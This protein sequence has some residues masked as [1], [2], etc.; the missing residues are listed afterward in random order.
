METD[1]LIIG[2]GLTGTVIASRIAEA[3]PNYE[4]TLVEAGTN[5]HS[6]PI[7]LAPAQAHALRESDHVWKDLST[8]QRHL[9]GRTISAITGKT[10][11]GSSAVNAGFWTR[12]SATDYDDWASKV[13]G[14]ERW[15]YESQLPYFKKSETWYDPQSNQDDHGFQGPVKVHSAKET[16][17]YPLREQVANAFL[18]AGIGLKLN[19]DAQAGDPIGISEWTENWHQGKSGVKVLTNAVAGKLLLDKGDSVDTHTAAKGVELVDGTIILARKEIVICCGAFRTPQLLMLSG[20]GPK[21]QLEAF[22]IPIILENEAVGQKLHD[23]I[24]LSMFYK[25]RNGSEKGWALGSPSFNKPEYAMGSPV[26]WLAI[27]SVNQENIKRGLALD[28]EREDHFLLVPGR[29]HTEMVIVYGPV[30]IGIPGLKPPL[31]GSIITTAVLNLLPTSRGSVTI[32]SSSATVSPNI[33][34]NYYAT[35]TDREILRAGIR[36]LLKVL[37]N[38]EDGVLDGE[39]VIEPWKSLTLDST[40]DDIDGRVKA[41][42]STWYHFGGSAAMGTVVDADLRVMGV[43]GLRIGDVSILPGPLGGHYQAAMYALAE[44]AADLII[45]GAK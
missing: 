26:D 7:I 3:L 27:S 36:N 4:V 24:S 43:R 14:G 32:T 1:Y 42:A 23:Q 31:D 11:S 6:N 22:N 12:C 8:P 35:H 39:L 29:P 45:E 37:N 15:R 41:T 33:D 19:K 2:G 21:A 40:D 20:I 44:Q 17:S 18:N 25:L 30:G 28:Q 16:R 34:P 13:P 10:L 38:F 9:N 5:E